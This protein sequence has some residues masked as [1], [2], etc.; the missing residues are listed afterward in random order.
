MEIILVI[1]GKGDNLQVAKDLQ[2]LVQMLR[3]IT[4]SEFKEGK[5][6]DFG[7]I[8]A[9]IESRTKGENYFG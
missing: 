1:T 2:I 4:E 7:T 5:I 3:V 8:V 9:Q 6:I